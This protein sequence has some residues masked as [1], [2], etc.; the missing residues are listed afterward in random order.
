MLCKY[1]NPR[2]TTSLEYGKNLYERHH[3][4]QAGLQFTLFGDHDA[5]VD[6]YIKVSRSHKQIVLGCA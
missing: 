1:F 5:A 3:Y 4:D 6:S 2:Q